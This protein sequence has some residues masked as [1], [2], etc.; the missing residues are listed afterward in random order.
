M[1]YHK[2]ASDMKIVSSANL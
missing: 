1:T 2:H